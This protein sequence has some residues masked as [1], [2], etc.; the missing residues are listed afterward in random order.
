M[1]ARPPPRLGTAKLG[2]AETVTRLSK[3]IPGRPLRYSRLHTFG[4]PGGLNGLQSWAYDLI[5]VLAILAYG[6]VHTANLSLGLNSSVTSNHVFFLC[7]L[8]PF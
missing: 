4:S 3:V 6:H 8:P 1:L 2:I 7:A 5:N